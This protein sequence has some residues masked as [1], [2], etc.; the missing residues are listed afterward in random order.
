M[1]GMKGRNKSVWYI[2]KIFVQQTKNLEM[3]KRLLLAFICLIA[4]ALKAQEWQLV[5]ADEFNGSGLDTS[6]WS[7]QTGTG[8]PLIGWGNNEL[9]FYTTRP[10]NVDVFD[11]HL[12]I[13]AQRENFGGMQYTSA[14]IRTR[15]K[16]DWRYG[17]IEMRAKLPTGRGLWPAFWML[18]TDEV[19]GGWPRS[20]EIDIMELVGHE[21]HRVHGTIHF[22]N[23]WPQNQWQGSSFT[24]PQGT[25]NDDFHTFWIEWEENQIRWHVDSTLYFVRVPSHLGAFNWPFN[26]RFHIILNVAV[27]GN[28]P[29]SPDAST[30]FPQAMVVDYVRVYQRSPLSAPP[31]AQ[32]PSR[33]SL[34][35]NYPN[36][37]N[38]TTVI[39][40]ELATPS[41][42]KLE[43][44]D[45]LGRKV[46]TLAESKQ[47][48]G[49]HQINFNAATYNLTSG[50]YFYKLTAGNFTQT[51]K[52]IL[53]K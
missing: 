27:G 43:V 40:Y 25:F 38:P 19:F 47:N 37:F 30:V 18:P 12:W 22:G 20:G 15:N 36:P 9:Q 32:K 44:F 51:R 53:T 52:M 21:P 50:M 42:V 7:Y 39:S 5:W 14:R 46:A 10:T 11:G 34:Q 16:G 3:K 29:G 26:E 8:T 23:A 2:E 31:I 1:D 17:R 49:A 33:F 41:D 6:K 35:Q 4:G 13:V 28:W 48:A 45:M 24:L